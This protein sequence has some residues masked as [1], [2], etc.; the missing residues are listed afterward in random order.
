HER[1]SIPWSRSP[2]QCRRSV[3]SSSDHSCIDRSLKMSI[4]GVDLNLF[5]VLHHV[6]REG[7]VARAAERLHV[8]PSAVSNS[9]ARLREIMGDPLF[10]RSGRKLVAT[11]GAQE[12]GP[13]ITAAIQNLRACLESNERFRR[14]SCTRSFTIAAADNVGV[15]PSVAERF[16]QLLPRA[17]LRVVTLDHAVAGDGLSSGEVDVLLALPPTM[18]REWR[19]EPAYTD[20]LVCGLSRDNPAARGKLTLERFLACRHVEVALQGKYAIDYVDGVLSGL[21]CSRSV[22][23]SVPQFTAAAMCVLGTPYIAMLPENMAKRL[24]SFLPLALREPPFAL[25]AI[26]ILQIWHARTDSDPASALLRGI[27]RD[28]GAPSPVRSV[29]WKRG[30]PRAPKAAPV[31]RRRRGQPR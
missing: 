11:P 30:T 21:G 28:A 15:L 20:R 8:T 14:E 29:R 10:V 3:L 1:S 4:E 18:S 16:S 6:L 24:A 9:L 22:A 23:L 27:I 2:I 5:L 7:S 17:T 12:L 13:L 31:R 25:P 19:S 26:T